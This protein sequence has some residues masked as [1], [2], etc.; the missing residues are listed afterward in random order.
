MCF[1]QNATNTR[2]VQMF[3]VLKK[4]NNRDG[5]L[6]CISA[7]YQFKCGGEMGPDSRALIGRPTQITREGGPGPILRGDPH[8]YHTWPKWSRTNFPV[9][10]LDFASDHSAVRASELWW[11]QFQLVTPNMHS[12]RRIANLCARDGNSVNDTNKIKWSVRTKQYA[13]RRQEQNNNKKNE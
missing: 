9:T 3:V 12:S 11:G 4:T 10:V 8:R 1:H 13:S 6:M 2:T 7:L 5:K